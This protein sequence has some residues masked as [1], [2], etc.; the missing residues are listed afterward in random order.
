MTKFIDL[1]GKKFGNLI[2]LKKTRN[3]K[4]RILWL[5]RCSC[6][7]EN[8]VSSNDLKSCHTKSCGC[9]KGKTRTE[10]NKKHGLTGTRIYRIWQCMKT[11]CFNK[12]REDY[13]AYGG[14]G[15]TVCDEWK[16]NFESFYDWSFKNG[17][18]D[19]LTLDRIDVNGNYCTEN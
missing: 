7:K 14:R 6:G 8:F 1:T 5:C 12:R 17:Y 11:R 3:E 10:L 2:V 13:K 19:N 4:N 18:S 15:I 9:L 16:D